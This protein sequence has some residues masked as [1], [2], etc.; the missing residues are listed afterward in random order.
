MKSSTNA[1]AQKTCAICLA[2]ADESELVF[3]DDL[4]VCVDCKPHYVQCLKE[5]INPFS[6]SLGTKAR[7][8]DILVVERNATICPNRCLV[9]GEP[10][11]GGI[12]ALKYFHRI[13][14]QQA[15]EEK[16]FWAWFHGTK[17]TIYH[18][19][20]RRHRNHASYARFSIFLWP[21]SWGGGFFVGAVLDNPFIFLGGLAL[22]AAAI[23]GMNLK[24]KIRPIKVTRQWVWLYGVSP[25]V[26]GLAR[27]EGIQLPTDV[28]PDAG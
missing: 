8:D 24:L 13:G 11:V 10:A 16:W 9:C 23:F 7:S 2:Q 14:S 6:A 5:G 25:L 22:G 3:F 20:C 17:G 27:K 21:I 1:G 12:A 19:L 26:R 15:R 28:E 18:G 4:P